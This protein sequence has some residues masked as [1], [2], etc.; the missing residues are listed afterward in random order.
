MSNLAEFSGAL[1]RQYLASPSLT[2]EQIAAL[3]AHYALLE[4]WNRS[5]NLTTVTGLEAVVQVHYCESLF[6]ATVLPPAPI[7]VLD[8]GCGGGFPGI[9]M[10]VA[11]PDCSFTLAESH[12]RKAVF[13][14]EATRGYKNVRVEARRAEELDT[15]GFDWVVSRAVRWPDVLPLA[16]K[17]V[18]LLVGGTDAEALRAAPDFAW[19]PPVPLPWGKNRLLVVGRRLTQ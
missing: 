15:A 18:A 4:R 5:L 2:P 9:P 13:L 3:F 19:E 10:A 16:A 14:K 11:R 17:F 6:A 8:V 12:Q 1:K 7:S